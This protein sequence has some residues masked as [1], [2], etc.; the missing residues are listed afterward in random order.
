MSPR[1]MKPNSICACGRKLCEAF[2]TVCGPRFCGGRFFSGKIM[3]TPLRSGPVSC[4]L[5]IRFDFY[6]VKEVGFLS[7]F[8]RYALGVLIGYAL[9]CLNPAWLLARRMGVDIRGKGTGNPGASNVFA[10]MG[11]RYGVLVA[12]FDIGKAMLAVWLSGILFPDLPLIREAAG[13]A[14][15]LGHMYPFY[16][17]FRGG[18]GFASSLGMIGGLNLR[19]A[20]CLGAVILL[21]IFITDYVVVGTVV[22][23]ISY[24][25]YCLFTHQTMAAL[26]VSVVSLIILYKHRQNYVRILNGTE[27]GVRKA[28]RGDLRVKK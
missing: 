2:L 27:T 4:M 26:I 18:K 28:G 7:L 24:P 10:L 9:G 21:L 19:F 12:V 22:T 15:V 11:K 5:Y 13:A 6:L 25:V 16:L 1:K 3:R 8:F 20:L 17:H 23:Q 14:S